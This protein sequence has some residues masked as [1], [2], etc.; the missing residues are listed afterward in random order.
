L[1]ERAGAARDEYDLP[2]QGL[3]GHSATL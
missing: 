3:A 1:T 2:M